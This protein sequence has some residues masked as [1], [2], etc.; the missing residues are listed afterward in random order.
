MSNA[1]ANA[2]TSMPRRRSE[3]LDDSGGLFEALDA[4]GTN[5]MVAD[6]DYKLIYVN[7]KSKETLE[8]ISGVLERELGVSSRDLVGRSIDDFHRGEAKLRVRRIL[9]DSR[10]LPYRKT[11]S[12]ADL[13]LDLNVSEIQVDG[14]RHGYVV[15]WDDVTNRERFEAE[16]A[17]L[18]SMMDNLPV[19]VMLVD[20]DLTLVYLNPASLRTLKALERF[21]PIPVDKIKGQK[22]DVFHKDPAHQR[23]VLADPKNLPIRSKIALGS[24]NLDLCVSPVF[25]KDQRYVGAMATWSVI[26]QEVKAFRDETAQ[27][28]QALLAASTQ[29]Q[30]T[31]QSAAAAAEET[32]KQTQVVGAASDQAAQG[33]GTVATAADEMTKAINEISNRIQESSRIASD[34]AKSV[35][36]SSSAMESLG[37]SSQEIG[38][39]VKIIS[40]IAQQTN[41]LALNATIEAARA[42]ESGRGFA[43]VANEVKELAKQTAK[44]TNEIEQQVA[45]IQ[46]ETEQAVRSTRSIAT[47]IAQINDASQSIAAS[48][49]EQ[50]AATNE[51]SRAA[52]LAAKSTTEVNRNIAHISEAATESSRGSIEIQSA[53]ATV[54]DVSA[55]LNDAIREFLK[56]MGL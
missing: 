32:A 1:F 10:N 55:K 47:T 11:I 2:S 12:L 33:V 36:T 8:R 30:A 4:I 31:S 16:S 42:G 21:L 29:L 41:L 37:K 14:K 45:R 23:R 48:V 49:E 25:D 26:S 56:K 38:Q 18:Q 46:G 24:E 51:I 28:V 54:A 43:V 17:R 5:V 44:A 9:G 52:D 20:L 50:N 7:R 19:N 53:A 27:I 39:F 35:E 22:I 40:A 15:N 6:A 13:R 34:A 3:F